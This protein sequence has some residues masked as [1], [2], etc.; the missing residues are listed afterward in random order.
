MNIAN[1]PSAPYA[2]GPAA[3]DQAGAASAVGTQIPP[4][5]TATEPKNNGCMSGC[6]GPVAASVVNSLAGLA[7]A[8]IGLLNKQDR[9]NHSSSRESL[10]K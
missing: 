9:C 5:S 10:P 3:T 6:T 2:P 1:S 7:T 4:R 8:V